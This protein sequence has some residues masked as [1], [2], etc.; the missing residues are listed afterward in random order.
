VEH[1]VIERLGVLFSAVVADILDELGYRNQ[2]MAP[3]I[4]PLYPKARL[5]GVARTV[6]AVPV[7]GVPKAA[8]DHYRLQLQA[9]DALKPGDVMVVS[10][11]ETCFWGELLSVAA[12]G[13]GAHG[14][15]I[16]GYARDTAGITDLAFPTF[17]AGIHAADALGRVEVAEHGCT[18]TAGDV[19]VHDGDIIIGDYDGVV[20]I[21][22]MVADEVLTL[23]AEKVRGERTVRLKLQEG[24]S[25]SEAYHRYGVL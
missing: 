13:R 3:R 4:R 1:S 14:I 10:R 6:R 24:M 2:V 25:L 11:I 15:V 23:A 12:R 22:S 8:E 5:A 20:V 7:D 21:P 17:V 16:D 19:V 9:I 18:I